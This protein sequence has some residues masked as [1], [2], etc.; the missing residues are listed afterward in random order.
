VCHDA[1]ECVE[2]TND[3]PAACAGNPCTSA[4]TCSAYGPEQRVCEPCDTDENCEDMNEY[5]VPMFYMGTLRGGY[6]LAD[7]TVGCAQPFSRPTARTSLSGRTDTYCGINETSATCEAVLALIDG[8]ACPGGGDVE[9]PLSGQCRTVGVEANRCTYP[10]EFTLD[11]PAVY[12]CVDGR[13]G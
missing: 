4:N 13:C 5:C 8:A 1:G 7:N 11:C 6:C 3:D 12:T 9:C 10:C 2:C